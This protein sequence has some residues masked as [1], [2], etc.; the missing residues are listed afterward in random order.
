MTGPPATRPLTRTA[1]SVNRAPQASEIL[2]RMDNGE[3]AG[4]VS[5]QFAEML[6]ASGAARSFRTGT[7]RYLRL[8][9]GIIIKPNLH[10]WDLIDEERR[11]HGDDAVRRGLASLD[12]RPLKWERPIDQR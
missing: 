4:R 7:R 1:P 5:Q 11:I 10:G 8:R 3:P 12:R 6:S 2:V 9:P